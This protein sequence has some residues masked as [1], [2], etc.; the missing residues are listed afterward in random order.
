MIDFAHGFYGVFALPQKTIFQV[1]SL[2]VEI[3]SL[4]SLLFKF[5]LYT[6]L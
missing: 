4:E 6:F 2:M 5:G 3:F 1:N